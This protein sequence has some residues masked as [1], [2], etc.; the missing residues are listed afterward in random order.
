[1]HAAAYVQDMRG[2]KAYTLSRNPEVRVALGGPADPEDD[3][4]DDEEEDDDWLPD[5]CKDARLCVFPQ[6]ADALACA[7]AC[8]GRLVQ[9]GSFEYRL[10]LGVHAR[11]ATKHP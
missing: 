10:T 3:P 2:K 11:A 6:I 8:D 4:D 5:R 9:P 1:M 7:A